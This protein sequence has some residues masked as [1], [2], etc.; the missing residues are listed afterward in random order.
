MKKIL[1]ILSIVSILFISLL[2]C[3]KDDD[4]NPIEEDRN[5]IETQTK[6]GLDIETGYIETTTDDDL[7]DVSYIPTL[8]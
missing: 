1:L 6:N 4:Y 2:S 8:H 5:K 3:N 7:T